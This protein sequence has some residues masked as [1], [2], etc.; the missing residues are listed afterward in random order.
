MHSYSPYF[1]LFTFPSGHEIRM[2]KPKSSLVLPKT[3][4]VLGNAKGKWDDYSIS[5]NQ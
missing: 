4:R 3:S 2:S 1:A 5:I